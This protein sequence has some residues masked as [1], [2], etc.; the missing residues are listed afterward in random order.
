MRDV[1]M[2][3]LMTLDGCFEG[4]TPWDLSFHD[5]AWNDELAQL[6]SEQLAAAG[7]LLFG[8]ATYDGMARHWQTAKGTT[9]NAMNAIEKLVFSSTLQSADWNNTRLVRG[10]PAAE[11]A[12]LRAQDGGP[13]MIAGSARLSASLIPAGVIDE[14]RICIVPTI[15]GAGRPLFPRDDP[16]LK[17]R[18]RLLGSTTTSKGCIIARYAPLT[19]SR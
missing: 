19:P 9:A 12:R 10:E 4:A 16:R 1:I 11:V 14:F 8:R 7:A 5:D 15:L 13:L 6:S 18:L 2:W 3:N 17:T